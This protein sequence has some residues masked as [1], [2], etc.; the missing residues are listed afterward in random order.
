MNTQDIT[1]EVQS[2]SEV[3]SLSL[4]TVFV[5]LVVTFGF[6]VLLGFI[7]SSIASTQI[8]Q[9]V[10]IFGI[11]SDVPASA[12]LI[13]SGA[14]VL[15]ALIGGWIVGASR[16]APNRASLL[17]NVGIAMVIYIIISI[18]ALSRLAV[19]GG[20]PI[21]QDGWAF[22]EYAGVLVIGV[23][24]A[25]IGYKPVSPPLLTTTKEV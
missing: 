14:N 18:F 22:A 3:R 9:Y 21:I 8:R 10:T 6:G 13:V 2:S 11:R 5:A 17:L 12:R 25:S 19:A 16:S 20:M 1:S 4:K 23:V 7:A 15:S 24:G